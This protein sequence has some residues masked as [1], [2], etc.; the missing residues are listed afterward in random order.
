[1]QPHALVAGATGLVGRRIAEH[2]HAAGWR[3]TGLCRRSPTKALPYEHCAVDLTNA[4]EC[5]A[6]LT[7]L[8]TVTHVFYAARY[9]H[10][11]G[12]RESIHVNAA[13]LENLIDAIE[14][15][16]RELRHVHLVHGTKYY[17]HMLG[18]L[19]L[20]LTE[21]HPRAAVPNFYFA[22]EDFVR[23]R[24][25]VHASTGSART[26][27]GSARTDGARTDEASSR[28]RS[29][30]ALSASKGEREWTY[31]TARPHTFCDA[32]A[33]EPRSAPLL[34]AVY[35]SLMRAADR[36]LDFPGSEES[37]HARTQFTYVPMLARAAQWM[38]SDPRCA[39]Q[40]YNIVNGD[41]PRWSDL[42]PLFADYFGVECGGPRR[43]RLRD[44]VTELE[45]VWQ[46]LVTQDALKPVPLAARVLWPYADYLFSPEWDIIS[47]PAKAQR[48][49]F[50]ETIDTARMFIE[51]FEG[52]RGEN[53]IP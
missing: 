49:G 8:T 22:Q 45:P 21:E 20:P 38:A 35:A 46:A 16:A 5:R 27:G 9:D 41:A 25:V 10:P 1:M 18:P 33:D 19:A 40:S 51:I 26:D 2:L 47:S 44:E 28:S 13:M 37:F 30:F 32:A 50:T 15:I 43:A 52:Y 23:G 39:N 48:D 36:A 17:G 7:H 42:W 34:I 12:E 31:S 53:V 11:E 6:K 14:P 3:V 24:S 4:D 29:P